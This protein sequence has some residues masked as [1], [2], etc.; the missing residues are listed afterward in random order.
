MDNAIVGLTG[1]T[2]FVLAEAST[3]W[4]ESV[5]PLSIVAIV[6]YYFL[7]KFDRKLDSLEDKTDDIQKDI[8]RIAGGADNANCRLDNPDNKN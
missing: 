2:C 4:I 8:K 7:W 5:T 1:A 3:S 6:V